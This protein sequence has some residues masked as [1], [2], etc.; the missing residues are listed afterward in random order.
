[1]R[2]GGGGGLVGGGGGLTSAHGIVTVI[3]WHVY[4]VNCG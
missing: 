1:M 3:D 2:V 4:P